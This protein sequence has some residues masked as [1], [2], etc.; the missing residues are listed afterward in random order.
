MKIKNE[1]CFETETESEKWISYSM[2]MNL[3]KDKQWAC[4]WFFKMSAK[5]VDWVIGSKLKL[6][7]IQEQ[8]LYD[9][10]RKDQEENEATMNKS[11]SQLFRFLKL[12]NCMSEYNLAAGHQFEFYHSIWERIDH[13]SAATMP[14]YQSA[15]C[16]FSSFVPQLHVDL[17]LTGSCGSRI[18]APMWHK[19][20]RFFVQKFI[21][22]FVWIHFLFIILPYWKL[23]SSH[24]FHRFIRLCDIWLILMFIVFYCV[25]FE[26]CQIFE[27]Y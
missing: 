18:Y 13:H 23:A 25:L 5:W 2:K 4:F 10:N 1:C 7:E 16:F 24:R 12:M 14:N 20:V 27:W 26:L 21:W 15:I 17:M 9:K 3:I 6:Q 11:K 19:F 22:Q 8:R